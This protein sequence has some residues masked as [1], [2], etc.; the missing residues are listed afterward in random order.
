MA[1]MIREGP[2]FPLICKGSY[3]SST[4]SSNA[5]S[6]FFDASSSGVGSIVVFD[7]SIEQ[8]DPVVKGVG[9]AGIFLLYQE[10]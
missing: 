9:R 8:Q 1:I 3:K 2:G 7:V 4:S 10:V 6:V 5:G